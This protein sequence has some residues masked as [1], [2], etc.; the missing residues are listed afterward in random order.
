MNCSN[1]ICNNEVSTFNCSSNGLDV[2][3]N[4]YYITKLINDYLCSTQYYF[5]SAFNCCD[6]YVLATVRGP[7]VGKLHKCLSRNA[8]LVIILLEQV[9]VSM[10][11]LCIAKIQ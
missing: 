5:Q 2:C 4:N 7:C 1:G 9:H 10:C 8:Y 11:P 3:N 6:G